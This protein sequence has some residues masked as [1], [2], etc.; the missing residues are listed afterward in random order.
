M[1]I[2]KNCLPRQNFDRRPQM[3]S[4][5]FC[6][7]FTFSLTK[8]LTSFR[9]HPTP[10]VLNSVKIWS[11]LVTQCIPK[12]SSVTFAV[13]SQAKFWNDFQIINVKTYFVSEYTFN[14]IVK[15]IEANTPIVIAK[16][17]RPNESHRSP[18]S[19]Y[20]K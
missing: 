9:K 3:I 18:E 7:F 20:I 14:S 4:M 5:S 10:T 12:R 8:E 15:A 13:K 6:P 2:V 1:R 19:F 17:A 11:S 16:T